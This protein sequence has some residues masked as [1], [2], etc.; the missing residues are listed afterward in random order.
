MSQSNGQVV[1]L[2][3]QVVRET[4]GRPRFEALYHVLRERI[5]LLD[6]P[7]GTNLTETELGEEFGVS[8]TPI[9]RALQALEADGLLETRAGIGS[10]VTAFD[11]A[12]MKDSYVLRMHLAELAGDFLPPYPVASLARDA[13][14]LHNKTMALG[15]HYDFRSLVK[16]NN[17]LQD[18]VCRCTGNEE[19][20]RISERL[21]YKTIRIY[22]DLVKSARLDW[23]DEVIATID[24][25]AA[26][27]KAISAN[28][29]RGVG[30][31]RRNCIWL[32]L[33]RLTEILGNI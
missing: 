14:T 19:L 31:V 23:H 27:M 2:H 26:V 7:P 30:F 9:R 32:V 4:R 17:S 16:T 15:D 3:L 29:G 25:T 18:L 8:R 28:D 13:E 12:S 20:R 24:E 33:R 22:Y 5:A 11:L 10:V 6:Y 1:P 21:Y